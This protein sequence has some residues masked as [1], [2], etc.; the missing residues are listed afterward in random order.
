MAGDRPAEC[1]PTWRYARRHVW[2]RKA[3]TY[4]RGR[5]PG[6]TFLDPYFLDARLSLAWRAAS[7]RRVLS[8]RLL[9]M[10]LL[11]WP[12]GLCFSAR[13]DPEGPAIS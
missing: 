5:A 10:Q 1:R 12:L 13:P 9:A 7:T 2:I 3:T 6:Q 4:G 8:N 11:R